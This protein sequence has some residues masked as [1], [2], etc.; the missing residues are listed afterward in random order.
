MG[1]PHPSPPGTVPIPPLLGA[2]A[3]TPHPRPRLAVPNPHPSWRINKACLEPPEQPLPGP[4][5]HRSSTSHRGRPVIRGSFAGAA[6]A[7]AAPGWGQRAQR[8]PPLGSSS[9][10]NPFFNSSPTG[11]LLALKTAVAPAAK[12]AG[13]PLP[14]C[15]APPRTSVALPGP[16]VH[17][18]RWG[19]IFVISAPPSRLSEIQQRVQ[20]LSRGRGRQAAHPWE[21]PGG[22][23]KAGIPGSNGK[24]QSGDGDSKAAVL[25]QGTRW[26]G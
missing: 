16:P 3:P 12:P 8:P 9:S 4:L 10:R 15:P 5:T 22:K 2:A 11:W 23:I 20:K 25:R 19:C 17:Q 14:R 18:P 1:H 21:E 7:G 13:F 6:W 26:Q 24:H